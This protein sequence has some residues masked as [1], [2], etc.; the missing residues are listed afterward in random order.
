MK[1]NN[2]VIYNGEKCKATSI[3][4]SLGVSDS[5]Y[6][7]RRKQG[8][9]AQEAFDRSVN[10]LLKPKQNITKFSR[11]NHTANKTTYEGLAKNKS[12][13][14]IKSDK[15]NKLH[16]EALFL[17][18]LYD[19]GMPKEFSDLYSFCRENGLHYSSIYYRIKKGYSLKEAVY[20]V[21]KNFLTGNNQYFIGNITISGFCQKYRLDYYEFMKYYKKCHNLEETLE[22]RIFNQTFNYNL[23]RRGSVL[24]NAF[25]EFQI[26]YEVPAISSEELKSFIL[27]D[28]RIRI[29]KRDLEYYEFLRE[30]SVLDIENNNIDTMVFKVLEDGVTFSLSELYFIFDLKNGLMKDFIYDYDKNIWSYNPRNIPIL[31]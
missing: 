26:N 1:Y 23:G 3:L 20:D 2:E 13:E 12:L 24:W 9:S 25:L 14:E 30:F 16:E 15:I 5:G 11:E 28:N 19:D 10:Y 22:R 4:K 7:K 17:N 29:I 31:K 8:M 6:F 21:S 27:A 18:K